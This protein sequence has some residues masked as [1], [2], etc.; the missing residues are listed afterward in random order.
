MPSSCGSY[1]V[2][3]PS[4]MPNAT[5]HPRPTHVHERLLGGVSVHGVVARILRL[6]GPVGP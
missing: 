6:L 3:F 5:H 2:Q 4:G 1:I